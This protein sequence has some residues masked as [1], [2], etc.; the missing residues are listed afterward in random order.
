MRRGLTVLKMRGSK[1]EK[2]IREFMIDGSGMHIGKPFRDISGIISGNTLQS[3]M[4]REIERMDNLFD[5]E[6]L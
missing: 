6:N 5:E 2:N 3:N 4:Q 1:H